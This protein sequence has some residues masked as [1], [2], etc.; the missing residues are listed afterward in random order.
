M[1]NIPPNN[2]IHVLIPKDVA[3][4]TSFDT[5]VACRLA[6]SKTGCRASVASLTTFLAALSLLG[7]SLHAELSLIAQSI[8]SLPSILCRVV[9]AFV[10]VVCFKI[11]AGSAT[12]L[13]IASVFLLMV[14]LSFVVVVH[15]FVLSL[16]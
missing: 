15:C 3:E 1:M 10:Y 5:S 11:V 9:T 14:T 6:V 8:V 13:L 12:S 16:E 7:R 4:V 2:G